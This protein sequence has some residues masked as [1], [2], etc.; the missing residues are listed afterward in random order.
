MARINIIF[1]LRS[2]CLIAVTFCVIFHLTQSD[3]IICG[4]AINNA[5]DMMCE[6]GFNTYRTKRSFPLEEITDDSNDEVDNFGLDQLPFWR[7]MSADSLTKL[8]RRR[9]G[10]YY[11]CCVKPCT[12][13]ELMTFCRP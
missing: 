9:D 6:N 12:K 8:R 5:L 11:E 3:S 10:V 7:S 2:V 13:A 1:G 4:K